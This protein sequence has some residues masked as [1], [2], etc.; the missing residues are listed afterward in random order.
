MSLEEK[1]CGWIGPSSDTEQ[2]KQ[3]RT[4]RMI[5]DAVSSHAPFNNCSLKIYAKGSYANNTNVRSDSDV[6]IAVECVDVLYWEED[7]PGSHTP[8]A[9]Y[10]GMWTPEKLRSELV[11]ALK[12][13]FPNQV[14]DTGTTAIQV[15]SSSSRVDADVV[16]CFSYKYFMKYGERSGTKIFKTNGSNVV[17]YPAQ[18]LENGIAKN[19]RTGYAYKKGVRLLKRI[20]NSM[21]EGGS[22]RALPSYFMECLAYNCPDS[23]FNH[24]T[25]TDCLRGMLFHIWDQLQGDEP[26]SGRWVEVN[27]CYYLFHPKQKWSRA[28]G[29]DFANA[30]W[31]YLGFK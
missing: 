11:A 15:N 13:K 7:E 31:N 3:D 30:A 21:V 18:Q 9:P 1:L 12:K 10:K 25:W 17:N 24:S 14:D 16:P 20:E 6:D 28:D 29:R 19:N 5:R 22:F 4:E 2:D 27:N 8:G 23:I 26:S